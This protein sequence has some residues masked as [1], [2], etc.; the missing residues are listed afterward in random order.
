[1]S[2]EQQQPVSLDGF[3]AELDV[4]S[5]PLDLLLYLVKQE[6]VDIFEVAVSRITERYL[7]ALQGIE[8][9]DVNTAAEFLVV[10][11]TLMEI[12]SRTL[13]PPGETAEEEEDTAGAELVRRLLQYKEFKEAAQSLEDR[14]GVQRLRYPRPRLVP[15]QEGGEEQDPALLLEDV[16]PWDLMAAF[17]RLLGETQLPASPTVVRN[18]VPVAFYITEVIAHLRATDRPVEFVEFFRKDASRERIVGVFLALLEMIRRRSIRVSEEEG[19]QGPSLRVSLA[20][21]P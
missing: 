18:E 13:L 1:M 2:D 9:Y 10:A 15:T 12:K 6:E 7:D 11:A 3:R 20:E 17:E 16:A 4:F 5:G 8:F 21:P 14:V 19:L